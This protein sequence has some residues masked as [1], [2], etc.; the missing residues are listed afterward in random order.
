MFVKVSKFI[1][2]HKESG[3]AI[4]HLFYAEGLGIPLICE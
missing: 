3:A 1:S 4:I 2:T